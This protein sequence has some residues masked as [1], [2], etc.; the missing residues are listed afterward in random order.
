MEQK[1]FDNDPHVKLAK[2]FF[3]KFDVSYSNVKNEKNTINLI[4]KSKEKSPQ[5]NNFWGMRAIEKELVR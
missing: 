2:E 3:E 5:E 4:F 1:D